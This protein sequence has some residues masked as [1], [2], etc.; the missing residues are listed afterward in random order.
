MANNKSYSIG[1]PLNNVFPS[2]IIMKTDPQA[3]NNQYQLGQVWVNQATQIAYMLTFI[4]PSSG[5]N[6]AQITEDGGNAIFTNLT[7]TN[8]ASFDMHL[9]NPF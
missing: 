7:V 4:S 5:A 1:Q 2:P 6:W 3:H 9:D 8:Q